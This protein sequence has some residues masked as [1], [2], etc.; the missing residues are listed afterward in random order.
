M[1]ALPPLPPLRRWA[2]W[3]AAG[4]P[5]WRPAPR[6]YAAIPEAPPQVS[7]AQCLVLAALVHALLVAIFGNTPGGSARPGEGVWGPINITLRGVPQTGTGA[8]LP[9]D[10]Y[11]GPVGAARD[12]RFGGA[13]RDERQAPRSND[14]PGAA[15]LG[16]WSSRP[17]ERAT[18]VAP[19]AMVPPLPAPPAPATAA[20][21]EPAQVAPLA[22]TMPSA[23]LPRP[24]PTPALPSASL[25]PEA[26]AAPPVPTRAPSLSERV[27][28]RSA[29]SRPS[30]VPRAAPTD[31]DARLKMVQSAPVATPA[32]TPA[33][34]TP[35]TLQSAAADAPSA[36]RALPEP[37][38]ELKALQALP[39]PRTST[40]T[41]APR[42][43][44]RDSARAEPLTLPALAAPPAAPVALSEPVIKTVPTLAPA[45]SI[46]A[47]TAAQPALDASARAPSLAAP[48][49][50]AVPGVAATTLPALA[51]GAPSATIST[52]T[53]PP[54]TNPDGARTAISTQPQPGAGAPD[55]GP[56]TGRDVATAP[57]APASAP[58][59]N[60]ELARPR[61]GEISREGS[62]GVLQLLPHP[63]ERK[64]KLAEDIANAAKKDCKQA[65]S[66]MGILAALPLAVDAVK[67]NAA[68]GCKW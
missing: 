19:G 60:L 55:A 21:A 29:E 27:A 67:S 9:R 45:P 54:S 37:A 1:I 41:S 8:V 53:A 52:T 12:S 62:R 2:A 18:E 4:V 15:R 31:S 11:S 3:V 7:V 42:E 44:A 20:P 34:P 24:M 66:G 61:G 25:A 36:A 13:V 51:S 68:T 26:T 30:D 40:S 47:P 22:R 63:P 65:Y 59:L 50:Q 28:P 38:V 48:Q 39:A 17:S 64:S 57:S 23:P 35:A 58:R 46:N 49:L 56:N 43:I 16:V 32:A 10:A 6:V 33:E 5:V 14:G